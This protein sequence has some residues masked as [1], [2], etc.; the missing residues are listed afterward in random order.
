[1]F[2]PKANKKTGKEL[3]IK[4]EIQLKSANSMVPIKYPALKLEQW[5]RKNVAAKTM[6]R[7]M[8]E[9][10]FFD[11]WGTTLYLLNL[12]LKRKGIFDLEPEVSYDEAGNAKLIMKKKE[13]RKNG[14]PD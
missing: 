5:T 3:K 6:L 8:W 4:I 13:E 10:G 11:A 14:E 12:D 9:H 7:W 1:M 2:N